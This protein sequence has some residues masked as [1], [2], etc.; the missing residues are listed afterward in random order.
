MASYQGKVK[1]HGFI[2]HFIASTSPSR[3]S[4]A[5]HTV[6]LAN[7]SI[8][9]SPSWAFTRWRHLDLW[10]RPSICTLLIYGPWKNERLSWPSLLTYSGRFTHIS[11]HPLAV[12]W[13][14]D[15][16][17]S[18][19]KDCSSRENRVNFC[20]SPEDCLW[21]YALVWCKLEKW[22]WWWSCCWWRHR[23]GDD[24]DDDDDDYVSTEWHRC[25]WPTNFSSRRTPRPEPVCVRHRR[26][27]C[28]SVVHG[29][30]ST[31]GDRAF[32]VT[33]TRTWNDLPRHV[34]SAPSLPVFCS[35]L[36]THLFRRSFPW[37]L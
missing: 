24:D 2:Q 16:W 28:L 22:W 21:C 27:R 3:C 25:T 1:V 29:C 11:G 37:L 15:G 34:T 31:V 6:L 17:S 32:P 5:D 30:P 14:Q 26:H 4:G 35:R 36:T 23:W 19:I 12:D 13:V 20:S 9:A 7:Y 10:W 18:P 8:P 33:A